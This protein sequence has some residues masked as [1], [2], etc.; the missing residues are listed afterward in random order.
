[1]S[2]IWNDSITYLLKWSRVLLEKLTDFQVVK[3]SP[4]FYGTR[5]FITALTSARH[6][7]EERPPIWRIDVNILNKQ[8]RTASKGWSCSLG[9]GQG[10]NNSS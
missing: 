4:T 3:K 8:S 7:I 6:R 10:A 1:M 2:S 5:R 9:V